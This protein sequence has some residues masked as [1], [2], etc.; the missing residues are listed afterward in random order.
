[1]NLSRFR[2]EANLEA[3]RYLELSRH[4]YKQERTDEGAYYSGAALG[5][6]VAM[7]LINDIEDE[8][9]LPS[10]KEIFDQLDAMPEKQAEHLAGRLQTALY[11]YYQRRKGD[12]K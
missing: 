11:M 10:V 3:R 5:V 1:M 2:R 6:A 12:D 8:S 4:F 7:K 9:P